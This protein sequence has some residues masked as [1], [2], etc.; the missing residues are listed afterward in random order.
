MIHL[1]IFYLLV[2]L[3]LFAIAVVVHVNMSALSLPV[4]PVISILTILL[5]VL[6]YL[7]ANAHPH[8]LSFARANSSARLKQLTP[9]ILQTLQGLL[10]TILATLLLQDAVPG[11]LSTCGLESRWMDLY[12]HKDG[13]TIR[14]IQDQLECC[15]LNSVKD[16]AYPFPK[17]G[18]STCADTYGR[19]QSCRD[20]WSASLRTNA[21]VDFGVVVAVGLLQ[22]FGLLITR[23]GAG[24]WTAWR[25]RSWYKTAGQHESNRPLLTAPERDEEEGADGGAPVRQGYGAATDANGGGPRV[26]PSSM[27]DRNAWSED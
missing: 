5:P 22:I 19:D 21:G 26:E 10:I 8:V 11:Q 16:R 9:Y 7:N 20:P 15:G 25:R 27:N 13:S 17:S 2:S 4:S 23:E 1:G 18:A 12:R 14:K 24:W 3:A 6:A